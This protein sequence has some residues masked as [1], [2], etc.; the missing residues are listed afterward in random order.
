M[1]EEDGLLYSEKREGRRA[2]K[3][4]NFFNIPHC[5]CYILELIS[6]IYLFKR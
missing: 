5:I 3:S 6:G 1:E 2:L 4:L